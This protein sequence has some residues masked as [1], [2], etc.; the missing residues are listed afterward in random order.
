MIQQDLREVGIDLDVRMYEFA[1][2]YADV[3]RGNFQ[4]LSQ[5]TGGSVADPD[6]LRRVLHSTQTAA[7]LQPWHFIDAA[8]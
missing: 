4:L 8:S 5:W 7:W 2:M 1:T 3:L 6:I